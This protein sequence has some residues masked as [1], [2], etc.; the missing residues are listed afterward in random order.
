[1][2][3]DH[4]LACSCDEVYLHVCW[5]DASDSKSATEH[6]SSS[7][8]VELHHLDHATSTSFDVVAARVKGNTFTDETYLRG[9]FRPSR[10]LVLQVNELRLR[11]CSLS[12][13][14]VAAHAH[15]LALLPAV[16]CELEHV[17]ERLLYHGGALGQ[18]FGRRDVRRRLHEVSCHRLA[19]CQSESSSNL[20]VQAIDA[21]SEKL[22]ARER[23]V[24]L[25]LGLESCALVSAK[26]EAIADVFNNRRGDA[27]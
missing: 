7:T 9:A 8:H 18:V 10:T 20:V 11:V 22:E 4:V 14:Q 25:L 5:L 6:S 19:L 12:N 13:T 17:R 16:D 23:T 26:E 24:A 15:V 2:A 3:I 27:R 21:A 1:M